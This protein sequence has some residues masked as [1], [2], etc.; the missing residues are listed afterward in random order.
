MEGRDACGSQAVGL[1]GVHN[2]AI[3]YSCYSHIQWGLTLLSLPFSKLALPGYEVASW[4][5]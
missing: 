2:P 5:P 1:A 3:C 4:V